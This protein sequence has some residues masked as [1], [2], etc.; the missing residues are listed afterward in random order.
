MDYF[1]KRPLLLCGLFGVIISWLGFFSYSA[2]FAVGLVLLVLFFWAIGRQL[3]VSHIVSLG[4]LI[5]LCVSVLLTLTHIQRLSVQNGRRTNGVFLVCE[6]PENHGIFDTVRLKTVQA[7]GLPVGEYVHASGALHHLET[8]NLIRANMVLSVP[9]DAYRKNFYA[10]R[11]YLSGT[12]EDFVLEKAEGDFLL[13]SLRRLRNGIADTLFDRMGYR[14][15]STLL[16]VV[17]GNRSYISDTFYGLV[18]AAGVSHVLVVSGMHLAIIISLMLNVAAFFGLKKPVRLLVL[19]MTVLAMSALCGFTPSILRAGACY[20]LYGAGILFDRENTPENTLGA[21]VLLLLISCPFLIFSV[22]FR[23]S[24]L[25]TLGI[26]CCALPIVRYIEETNLLRNR[27]FKALVSA[28]LIT[29]SALLFTL[30]TAL[31]VFGWFSAVSV[32]TNLLISYAVTLVLTMT[33]PILSLSAF[34]PSLTSPFFWFPEILMRYVNDV[35][36]LF[37][38]LPFATVEAGCFGVAAAVLVLSAVIV[39]LLLVRRSLILKKQKKADEKIR[40]ETRPRFR[41]R[42]VK[43]D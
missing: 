5:A 1:W 41:P 23:L 31:S 20:L 39:L 10:N 30:P 7:D 17:T 15:A 21:A 3:S 37:G 29:L 2:V 34:L 25:S 40:N 16:A 36:T 18:K 26:V 19:I 11:E 14:E 8:G 32:P 42:E 13:R 28:V 22:S 38:S 4:L 43:K 33:I 27:F 24:V 6:E 12:V 9:K 35:I